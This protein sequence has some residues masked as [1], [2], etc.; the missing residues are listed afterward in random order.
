M[1]FMAA[2]YSY[3]PTSI[4]LIML[5]SALALSVIQTP[6]ASF[7]FK[8]GL[9]ALAALSLGIAVKPILFPAIAILFA[10]PGRAFAS[11]RSRRTW[12]ALVTLAM[13]A[14]LATFALPF[15]TSSGTSYNDTR[16]GTDISAT[17]QIGYIL[18]HPV[19]F[20]GTMTRWAVAYLFP[21]SLAEVPLNLCYLPRPF[22][23][24][25]A[26]ILEWGTVIALAL[27]SRD[28]KYRELGTG[29]RVFATCAL[30]AALVMMAVSL[31]LSFSNV[32]AF[33]LNGMQPR[34]LL[35]VLFP[36]FAF[37]P[38]P[39]TR[40]AAPATA[41]KIRRYAVRI[42]CGVVAYVIIFGFFINML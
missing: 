28:E 11:K 30:V 36:L 32:G 8:K 3:D 1:L 14:V 7:T 37:C 29:R 39:A 38:K 22:G 17:R 6:G 33:N 24:P 27:S 20:V 26:S 25:V 10:I 5:G 9:P 34:Y 35:M 4:A 40:L 12:C 18:A 13:L 15:L 2:N 16:G 21:A 23:W 41:E 19:E 31:Y 42:Q